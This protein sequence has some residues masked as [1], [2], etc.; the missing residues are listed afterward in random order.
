MKEDKKEEKM[1]EIK[2][3]KKEEKKVEPKKKLNRADFIF[4]GK[5]SE[6]LIKKAG[7]IN[8]IEFKI[9]DL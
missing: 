8:G 9:Q 1:E 7:D 2:E 3:E 5:S 4:K 6:T